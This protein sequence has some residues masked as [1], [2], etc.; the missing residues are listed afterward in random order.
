MQT[1]ASNYDVLVTLEDGSCLYQGCTDSTAFNHDPSATLPGECIAI[2]LG[3]L[4]PLA[5]N[6]RKDV[7]T[8]SG[9]CAYAGCTDS[10]HPNYNPTATF[11]DGRCAPLFP[12]CT[13]PRAFNYQPAYNQDDGSCR[14]P[15]CMDKTNSFFDPE[16]TINFP[17]LC[18]GYVPAP[19]RKLSHGSGGALCAD[20]TAINYWP[21][22]IKYYTEHLDVL[23]SG[24]ECVY[25]VLGCTDSEASNYLAIADTDD[26]SCTFSVYGCTDATATNF[27][28]TATVLEG[29][30]YVPARRRKLSHGSGG[31]LCADPTAINYWP[32]AIK[33]YK[34]HLDVLT[35][36]SECVYPV[37]GCTDSD[38]INYRA[39]A[40]TDNGGCTFPV[41]GCT[42]AM[43]TNFDS[44]A[45][46]HDTVHEG[47]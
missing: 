40:N 22:A 46:V 20:P 26:G 44:N 45:T 1:D 42:D 33:Y 47:C 13:N 17:F 28:S 6:F 16:A 29:C 27:D 7:N 37:L 8:A 11:N 3:C 4:E 21:E 19:R 41:Y 38:A 32:E 39:A 31:A 2:V 12:G 36:G 24:S 5:L 23:T 18:S 30:V 9:Y 43:A 10:A 34:E 25:P 15:G 14:I 35:S